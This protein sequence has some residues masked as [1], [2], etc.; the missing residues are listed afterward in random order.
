MYRASWQDEDGGEGG[1]GVLPTTPAERTKMS[2]VKRVMCATN[3]LSWE[4][5]DEGCAAGDVCATYHPNWEDKDRGGG[6]EEECYLPP[7]LRGQRWGGGA[8]YHPSWEDEDQMCVS[9]SEEDKD[10]GGG[11]GGGGGRWVLPTTPTERTKMRGRGGVM[12]APYHPNSKDKDEGEGG[13]ECSLPPQLKGQRWGGG[14]W[15]VLPTTPTERT[16]MRGR[17]VM[18]APYHPNW[19]DKDEGEGGDEC[20]LPPQLKGQRW[21]G[22][23]GDD[24]CYL[25]PQLRGRRWGA[26]DRWSLPTPAP[27]WEQ[28]A[29]QSWSPSCW[30]WRMSRKMT[31]GPAAATA[32]SA[33]AA[34]HCKSSP[35]HL[36]KCWWC[37]SDDDNAVQW[38]AAAHCKSSPTHLHKCW[39]CHSDDANAKMIHF[40]T[41]QTFSHTSA[42]MAMMS[43]WWC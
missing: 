38:L 17:G 12:S 1:R 15:W 23:G 42:Q 24:D 22:G 25:P 7:Q 4:D 8:T 5:E 2:V 32:Q 10:G 33:C 6:G 16:K 41:L 43:Q 35:T 37:H 26:C 28:E 20:S 19:K 11:W 21:V 13:D 29:P 36:H 31:R 39:W 9:P 18:S 40:S 30:W 3:H 34:A 27:C 14:G